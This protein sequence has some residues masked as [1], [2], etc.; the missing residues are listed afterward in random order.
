MH[1]P[2][3]YGHPSRRAQESAPQDEGLCVL[4]RRFSVIARSTCDEAIQCFA[5]T[6]FVAQELDCF[7]TLAMTAR[8]T[9]RLNALFKRKHPKKKKDQLSLAQ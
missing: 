2:A 7:A 9:R 3:A 8:D 6:I 1:A 5:S 4:R